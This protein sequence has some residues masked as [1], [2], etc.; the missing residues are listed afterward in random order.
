MECFGH[1]FA[2]PFLVFCLEKLLSHLAGSNF[3]NLKPR[4]C[5]AFLG[6]RRR[7]GGG[8]A[9]FGVGETEEEGATILPNLL[10]LG[11]IDWFWGLSREVQAMA[12]IVY[13]H[14]CQ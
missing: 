4:C 8:G 2:N 3:L 13:D 9:D 6:C 7:G 5:C 10:W 14:I 12:L 1:G 11:R